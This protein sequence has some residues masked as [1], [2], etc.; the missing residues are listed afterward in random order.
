MAKKNEKTRDDISITGN[1]A[2]WSPRLE[3]DINGTY[4]GTFK[5]RC[6]L[7]PTQRISANRKYREMLGVNPTLAGEHESNLA[8]ALTQLEQRI[9]EAPPYWT[10]TAQISGVEGDLFDDSVIMAA[11]D[12]AIGAEIKYRDELKKRKDEALKRSRKAADK[13]I[14]ENKVEEEVEEDGEVKT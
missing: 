3:G 11:L 13:L 10:S 4:L 1:V 5:F 7:S 8:Y 6:V 12:A 14:E 2:T 9:I